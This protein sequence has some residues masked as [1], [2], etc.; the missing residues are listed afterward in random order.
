MLTGDK[1][2]NV[3]FEVHLTEKDIVSIYGGVGGADKS[4]IGRPWWHTHGGGH[5]IA[6]LRKDIG[7]L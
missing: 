3:Q 6:N 7:N 1:Y 5:S 2:D 4:H